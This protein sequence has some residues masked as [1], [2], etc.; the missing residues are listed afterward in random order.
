[1]E[2]EA[3]RELDWEE[4]RNRERCGDL[5]RHEEQ[6]LTMKEM[7]ALEKT[8]FKKIESHSRTFDDTFENV[9]LSFQRNFSK[10]TYINVS[11]IRTTI[12]S[13]LSNR[14][15]VM[16]ERFPHLCEQYCPQI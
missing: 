15:L 14:C 13:S 4:D 3:D 5:M 11:E 2:K 12:I 16:I 10:P 7:K 9:V 6:E 8:D 1:M